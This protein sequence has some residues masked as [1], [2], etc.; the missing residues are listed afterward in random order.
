MRGNT[1]GKLFSIT[2]FGES[3]GTALGVTI[4]GMPSNLDVDLTELQTWLNK[5]RPGRLKISTSRD[6]LDKIEVLSG[7]FNGKTLGTPIT[8]IIKN[9]NQKSENY[10]E[11]KNSP[12]PGHA[13][14]T[15]LMKFG[16]RDHR[17]GGRSSGRETVSRVIGG[18]FAS[19]IIKEVHI[20]SFI[21]QI[22]HFKNETI[23]FDQQQ[24]EI[25]FSDISM[26]PQIES[27][28]L[29]CKSTCVSCGVSIKI[30][31]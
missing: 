10:K 30:I 6:E 26:E 5:R 14:E 18:Y 4:D 2:S 3:H 22:A 1:F 29:E 20:E 17:G 27:F 12:R 16:I 19:L 7:I 21:T 8:I 31:A 23:N 25:G 28:L 15:T 13:D 9:T 24:G 11:L